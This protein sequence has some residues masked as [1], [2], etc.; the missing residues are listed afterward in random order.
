MRV[1]RDG[2]RIDQVGVDNDPVALACQIKKAGPNPRWCWR[3]P[4]AWYWA[5]DV[6]QAAGAGCI[7]PTRWACACSPNGGSHAT[8]SCATNY[9]AIAARRGKPIAK[10]IAGRKLLAHVFYGMRDGYIR[11]LG[12]QPR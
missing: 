1:G 5:V 4:T 3:P 7:C 6:L 10:V 9:E 12:Q 2:E 11:A 8:P